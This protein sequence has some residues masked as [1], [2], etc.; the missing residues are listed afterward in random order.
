MIQDQGRLSGEGIELT[1]K[2]VDSLIPGHY[3]QLTTL[4]KLLMTKYRQKLGLK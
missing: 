4:G 3:D 2:Q 1:I